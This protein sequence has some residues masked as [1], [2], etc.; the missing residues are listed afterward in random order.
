[1]SEQGEVVLDVCGLVGCW[2]VIE[3]HAGPG[4]RRRYCSDEHRRD[5]DTMR[6]RAVARIDHLAALLERERHLL[7]ALGGA[8][9]ATDG[10]AS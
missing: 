1:M 5:A 6:K 7:A 4:R 2:T 9:T 3:S 8:V 10:S